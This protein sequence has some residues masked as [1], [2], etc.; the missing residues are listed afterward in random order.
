MGLVWRC[1]STRIRS[2]YCSAFSSPNRYAWFKRRS[3]RM[4]TFKE[5]AQQERN[6]QATAAGM[7]QAMRTMPSGPPVSQGPGPG[8]YQDKDGKT[9]YWNGTGWTEHVQP[10]GAK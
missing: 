5:Q 10:E 1:P 4:M 2:S 9:R 8:W 3:S 7:K 6:I